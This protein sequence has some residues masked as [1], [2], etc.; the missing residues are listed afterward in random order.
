M[1][2]QAKIEKIKGNRIFLRSVPHEECS[3][4]S[5]C[6]ASR[7]RKTSLKVERP[8]RY[9]EGEEVWLEIGPDKM[10]KVYLL[11][12]GLPLML[13]LAGS[14]GT[15]YFYENAVA[16]FFAGILFIVAG[17]F[18]AARKLKSSRSLQPFVKKKQITSG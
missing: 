9:E 17:Y 6:G 4:C 5:S 10:M 16:S 15:F 1:K 2:E 12:Y 13:F 7:A 8:E 18:F 3:G 14:V 11:L